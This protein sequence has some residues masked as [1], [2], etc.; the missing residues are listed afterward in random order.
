MNEIIQSKKTTV[1]MVIELY[2]KENK[3]LK[4]KIEQ[5]EQKIEKL[6]N[7][8]EQMLIDERDK[9]E[10]IYREVI[11]TKLLLENSNKTVVHDVTYE[12]EH[13]KNQLV[14]LKRYLKSLGLNS[15]R[16]KVIKDRFSKAYD[17]D[18]RIIKQNGKVF[19]DF[20]KYDYSDLL[21]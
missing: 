14:E 13:N 2:Q 12:I 6:V 10:A 11:S 16:K 3:L 8:K 4:D 19:L 5:L 7:D 9:I 17:D 1:A 18:V 15:K 20:S 21:K